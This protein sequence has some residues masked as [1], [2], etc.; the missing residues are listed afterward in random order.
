M[1]S[2]FLVY[3]VNSILYIMIHC[4]SNKDNKPGQWLFLWMTAFELQCLS[5]YEHAGQGLLLATQLCP[6]LSVAPQ[7]LVDQCEFILPFDGE[8]WGE[9]VVLVLQYSHGG[10]VQVLPV[11]KPGHACV[12]FVLILKSRYQDLEKLRDQILFL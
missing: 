8:E 9:W 3:W 5:Y 4:K 6:L 10:T 11:G 1:G 2:F 7:E 12:S